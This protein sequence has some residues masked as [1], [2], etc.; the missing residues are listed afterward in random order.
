MRSDGQR[1]H[2]R[3]GVSSGHRRRV[4]HGVQLGRHGGHGRAGRRHGRR[5]TARHAVMGRLGVGGGRHGRRHGRRLVVRG[6]VG[7][8]GRGRRRHAAD[9]HRRRRHGLIV[10]RLHAAAAAAVACRPIGG[11]GQPGHDRVPPLVA[12]A[13]LSERTA[14]VPGPATSIAVRVADAET[15]FALVN[16]LEGG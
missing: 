5:V 2:L 6:R 12:R 13:V 8:R 15:M 9:D 11:R 1:T 16:V 3:G 7:A 14:V 4:G 10:G